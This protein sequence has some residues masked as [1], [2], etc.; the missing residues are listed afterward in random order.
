MRII[1]RFCPPDNVR[2]F[3]KEYNLW[4]HILF[5]HLDE[6]K[7]AGILMPICSTGI[8]EKIFKDNMR[9][10]EQIREYK[11]DLTQ[12]RT[13]LKKRFLKSMFGRKC[14]MKNPSQESFF[15]SQLESLLDNKFTRL[16]Y[17]EHFKYVNAYNMLVALLKQAEAK[18]L[19]FN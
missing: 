1:C 18:Q 19:I 6:T 4:S 5:E 11:R 7:Q 15:V 14:D 9:L 12:L 2:C 16:K 3:Y 10:I 8:T 17:V 13:D